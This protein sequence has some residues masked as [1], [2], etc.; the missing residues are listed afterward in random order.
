[1]NQ[2]RNLCAVVDY[3]LNLI[4]TFGLIIQLASITWVIYQ[5]LYARNM[6]SH[7]FSLFVG[8]PKHKAAAFIF[9]LVVNWLNLKSH[10]V[11]SVTSQK[12]NLVTR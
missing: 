5:T 1:M 12:Q 4:S 2:A 10:Q 8:K 3:D 9:V 6:F 7:S 11:K